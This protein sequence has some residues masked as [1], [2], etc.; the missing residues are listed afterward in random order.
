MLLRI[1]FFDKSRVI[2]AKILFCGHLNLCVNLFFCENLC[3]LWL[4]SG[5]KLKLTREVELDVLKVLLRH[6]QHITRVG[7]EHVAS[8]LVL[9]H[10]L[11]LALLEVFQFRIIVALN[12][13]SL[14]QMH[15]FPT[16]LCIVLILQTVL[17]DLELQLS[18]GTDDLSVV[19]LVDKQLSDTLVHQLVDTL[20]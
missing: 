15:R 13:T 4:S 18:H 6:R 1:R 9:G 14:I 10:I 19:E 11:V 3:N 7:E 8:L 2:R 12:P 20:L 5:P 17:D 16:A